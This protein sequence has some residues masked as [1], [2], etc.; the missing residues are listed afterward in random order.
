MADARHGSEGPQA[1]TESS[2]VA[3]TNPQAKAWA[4]PRIVLK[5]KGVPSPLFRVGIT[6]TERSA[7]GAHAIGGPDASAR[8]VRHPH[9]L[10]HAGRAG[11]TGFREHAV[12]L[13][14]AE[15]V[16]R[17][18]GGPGLAAAAPDGGHEQQSEEKIAFHGRLSFGYG[19]Q[20]V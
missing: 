9:R 16:A 19:V 20:L 11:D 18:A 4:R 15:R 10:A 1:A 6:A 2:D 7:S 3:A 14:L 17:R 12:A 5:H 8:R 13:P